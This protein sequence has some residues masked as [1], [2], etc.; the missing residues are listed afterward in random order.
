M[1]YSAMCFTECCNNLLNRNLSWRIAVNMGNYV[2]MFM[3][4]RIQSVC[5]IIIIRM[6]QLAGLIYTQ[7]CGSEM[8]TRCVENEAKNVYVVGFGCKQR[9]V[10]CRSVCQWHLTAG[11]FLIT[12]HAVCT[13]VNEYCVNLK[14]FD[15]NDRMDWTG[16]LYVI[17]RLAVLFLAH[18]EQRLTM[19]CSKTQS[20]S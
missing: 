11:C 20:F 1:P 16:T 17:F 8:L 15:L 13:T 10:H 3:S 6:G 2:L 9:I 5:W 12:C 4:A 7:I 18:E 19:A 14:L